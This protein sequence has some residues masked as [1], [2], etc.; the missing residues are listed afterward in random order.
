MTEKNSSSKNNSPLVRDGNAA[1]VLFLDLSMLDADLD[2]TLRALDWWNRVRAG[3]CEVLT[4]DHNAPAPDWVGR[5]A[6]PKELLAAATKAPSQALALL[7]AD[8]V[9]FDPQVMHRGLDRL[10]SCGEAWDVFTQWEHC[11]LPVGVGI[12]AV[13]ARAVPDLVRI[14]A[15]VQDQVAD[16]GTGRITNQIT[17]QTTGQ[18]LESGCSRSLEEL[19]FQPEVT[20]K[21]DDLPH[22]SH[23]ESLLDAR[24]GRTPG[25]AALL[26]GAAPA[27]A[28]A[29]PLQHFLAAAAGH[30]AELRYQPRRKAPYCDAR[31]MPAPIGFETEECATF[32]TY[33][34]F[35]I[36]NVCNSRC[37]HC[38]HSTT[39]TG[40][41][42]PRQHLDWDVFRRAVDE[43]RGRHLE[44]VRVTADGEPLLHPRLTDMLA[45]AAQQGVG[46]LGLTTNGMLMTPERSRAILETGLDVVDFSLDAA[47]ARTYAVIRRGLD[48]DT[49]VS[50]VERFLALRDQINPQCKVMVSFVEQEANTGERQDFERLWNHRADKVLIRSLLS[51]INLVDVGTTSAPQQRHPCPHPFRRMVISYDGRLKYCPVDWE[52]RTCV[53]APDDRSIGRAW[54]G[55]TCRAARLDHLNLRFPAGGPCRECRDWQGSPWNLGYEKVIHK[56][57]E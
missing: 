42:H 14:L 44:F 39:F 31:H 38:P 7:R 36:T 43:C 13:H 25:M 34:M 24:M 56:L 22:A 21:Y 46:P 49:V 41:R 27:G 20:V 55:E 51:N 48:Y 57:K 26:R 40:D 2:R 4:L 10:A 29:G 3:G 30:H 17:S 19:L 8:Q 52:M 18:S 12:R 1:P 11:R 6:D 5:I 23:Q 33:V 54:H 9:F 47:N 28:E 37:I 15:R 45:Y 53:A 35:D 32:P 50:N 16:Q